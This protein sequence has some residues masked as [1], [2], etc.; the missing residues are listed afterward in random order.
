MDEWKEYEK[1]KA[2]LR[3]LPPDKYQ[4]AVRKLA[5]RLGL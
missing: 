3:D 5:G 4:E 1:E 2:K